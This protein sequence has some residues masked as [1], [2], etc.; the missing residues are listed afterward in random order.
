MLIKNVFSS[1]LKKLEIDRAAFWALLSMGWTVVSGPMILFVIA[2]RFSPTLQGFY[3]SFTNLLNFQFLADLGFGFL[4]IQY[5]GHEFSKLHINNNGILT[6]D[7]NSLSKMVHLGHFALKWF[8]F[9]SILFII[10]LIVVG[11]ILFSKYDSENISWFLPWIIVVVITGLN[12][13]FIPALS[14][15]EGCNLVTLV[16]KYRFINGVITVSFCCLAI[17]LGAKLWCRVIFAIAGL[18][19][20]IIFL[21]TKCNKFF[22]PFFQSVSKAR[23][24]WRTEIFSMFWRHALHGIGVYISYSFFVPVLFHYHGPVLAGKMGMSWSVIFALSVL[25]SMVVYTKCS[26][27][28]KMIANKEFKLLDHLFYRSTLGAI[29]VCAVGAFVI[30]FL[31]YIFN[32]L[33][34]PFTQRLLSPLPMAILLLANIFLQIQYA[35]GIYLRAHKKEVLLSVSLVSGILLIL[36][37]FIFGKWYGAL[38]I[39]VG[40][41]CIVVFFILPYGTFVWYKYRKLWHN[42]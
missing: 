7:A 40:Y 14:L 34:I 25:S 15:L 23:I 20:T 5:T 35:Q 2:F 9:T 12:I 16:Y 27:F 42:L 6:G 17:I 32:I 11:Y 38:G 19:W 22:R 21:V 41:F 10:G 30:W 31:V 29:S 1:V 33:D 39:A 13:I 3:Y 26:R 24:D 37:T 4:I 18:V 36:L 8:L 28:T